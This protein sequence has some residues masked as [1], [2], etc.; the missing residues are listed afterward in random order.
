[1]AG[2]FSYKRVALLHPP[3]RITGKEP[4]NVDFILFLC[5]LIGAHTKL[6]SSQF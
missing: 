2:N 1:M 6:Q 3:T 5:N 4:Q